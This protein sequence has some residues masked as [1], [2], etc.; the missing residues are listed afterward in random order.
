MKRNEEAGGGGL[1]E[2]GLTRAIR[3]RFAYL[4]SPEQREAFLRHPP[5]ADEEN[6]RELTRRALDLLSAALF[7]YLVLVEGETPCRAAV[8][9]EALD[10][11]APRRRPG[12]ADPLAGRLA[13]VGAEREWI[14]TP[15]PDHDREQSLAW[16]ERMG[17]LLT[18]AGSLRADLEEEVRRHLAGGGLTPGEI[19]RR[20]EEAARLWRAA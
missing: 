16:V 14:P 8:R 3:G 4:W 1:R 2:L 6:W 17:R 10:G 11:G 18:E 5:F 7:A 15:R 19:E 13:A 9:S 20:T 12:A